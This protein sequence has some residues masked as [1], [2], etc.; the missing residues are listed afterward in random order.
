MKIE[1]GDNLLK[2]IEK[3]IAA[4]WREGIGDNLQK[5]FGINMN[6]LIKFELNKEEDKKE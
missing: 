6:E 5:S 4:S 2:A 1:I 3:V